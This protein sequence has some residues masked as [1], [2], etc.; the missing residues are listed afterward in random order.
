M[1]ALRHFATLLQVL[2]I[3]CVLPQGANARAINEEMFVRIGGIE[4][5]ITI[6]GSD[7]AN[8]VILV[9]HG[10]PGDA[11]SPVAD[12]MFAG[13]DKDFTMVQWDQPGAGRTYGKTGS[14][15]DATMTM[16]RMTQDGIE[17]SEYLTRHLDKTKIIL[18][19]GSWGSILGIYMV[20]ARPDLFYAYVGQAQIV[21]WQ[22]NVSASYARVLQMAKAAKDTE[23]VTALNSIGPPPWK[24]VFP[25]WR[26]YRK[27]EQAYQ[28]KIVTAPNAPERIS[29]AYAGSAE[30]KQYSEAEDFSMFHFWSGR[31]P[32]TK[33]DL[34]NLPMSGPLTTI[35]LPGLGTDFKIPIYIVQG[36]ADLT[37]LPELAKVYFDSIKAPHKG[38]YLVPGTGHEPSNA[39]MDTTR[40]IL[41][42]QVKPLAK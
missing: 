33:A 40:N 22:K 31:Q 12:S 41:L 23:T 21:N 7:S 2:A 4:Q 10:G 3:T 19:G 18:T 24:T 26:T 38:F 30:R 1:I 17:V 9:L 13:W 28:A 16:E 32:R 27:A 34:T 20:H 29:A 5:W 25:Q 39:M 42:G 11:L 15:V 35:D 8:P 37:A 6:K 14:A 36:Q